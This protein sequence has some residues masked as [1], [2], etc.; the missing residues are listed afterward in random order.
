MGDL[1]LCLKTACGSEI[2]G[3]IKVCSMCFFYLLLEERSILKWLVP[4]TQFWLSSY[5]C[6]LWLS[7]WTF[8]TTAW[9]TGKDT[10]QYNHQGIINSLPNYFWYCSESLKLISH[11]CHP[12]QNAQC[13]KSISVHRCYFHTYMTQNK[14]Y[15]ASSPQNYQ[16]YF[17]LMIF[18]FLYSPQLHL[19]AL[20]SKKYKNT[21]SKNNDP[22]VNATGTTFH[23]WGI[24]IIVNG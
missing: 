21:G 20:K 22:K 2:V 13:I 24:W 18:L 17:I 5:I 15:N 3:K 7:E 10:K 14:V 19:A 9:K 1:L 4:A 23:P 12:E 8:R 6:K 16:F 11:L